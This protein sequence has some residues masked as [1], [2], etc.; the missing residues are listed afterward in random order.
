[1]VVIGRDRYD[2]LTFLNRKECKQGE[3][4]VDCC[5]HGSDSD[6]VSI[7]HTTAYA[8]LGLPLNLYMIAPSST[9]FLVR[10]Q[11]KIHSEQNEM[12]LVKNTTQ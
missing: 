4:S 7:T 6:N 1:M 2:D 5:S 9:I 12:I 8:L 3:R 10:T 11:C